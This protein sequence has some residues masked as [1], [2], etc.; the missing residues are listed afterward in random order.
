M[1][2]PDTVAV[3]TL[4]RTYWSSAGRKLSPETPEDERERA[5]AAGVMFAGVEEAG[6]DRLVSTVRRLASSKPR[7]GCRCLRVIVGNQG[8]RRSIGARQPH[9][10][11]ASARLLVH[12]AIRR[13]V[14]CRL[15]PAPTN[16]IDRNVLSFERF[17]HPG[18]AQPDDADRALAQF[19]LDDL[20]QAPAKITA[21]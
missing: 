18:H 10:R 15:R 13:T 16:S 1:Q 2:A 4:L 3:R 17:E 9:R 11:S 7:R 6:H 12:G 5:I 20:A 19:V 8:T 14:L 21:P